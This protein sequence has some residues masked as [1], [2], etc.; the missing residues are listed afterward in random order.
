MIFGCGL[1]RTG[2]KSLGRALS[3]LGYRT[4]KYPKVIEELGSLY[5]AAVDITVI[6]WMDELDA[7][8]PDAKWVLTLRDVDEWIAGCDRWFARRID[9]FPDFKQTYLRHYRQVVYG[10][11]DFDPQ[12]WRD[13]YHRHID[14]VLQHFQDRPEQLLKIN[15]CEG[16]G[17]DVLCPFLG[18]D[19]PDQPFPSIQ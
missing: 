5:D 18:H 9:T 7:K 3:V 17:W 16:E 11:E 15:I 4:V 14:R 6:A 13:A 8:F 2:N 19:I 10:A 12:V 1:S